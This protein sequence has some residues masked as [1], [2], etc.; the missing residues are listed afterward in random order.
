MA[1]ITRLG[2]IGR[3]RARLARPIRFAAVGLVS[4]AVQLGCLA[5][6]VQFGVSHDPA[7]FAALLTSAQVNFLLSAAVIWPDRPTSIREPG[8][9]LQRLVAFNA[10]SARRC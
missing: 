2:W 7:N 1:A 10:M 5:A 9:L 6:L 4:S 8:R 3:G